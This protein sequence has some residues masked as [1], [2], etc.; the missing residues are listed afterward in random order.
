MVFK[1]NVAA[2]L[3]SVALPCR[4]VAKNTRLLSTI[5]VLG[6]VAESHGKDSHLLNCC[7]EEEHG[8]LLC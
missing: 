6:T 5:A 3:R 1:K 4:K 2:I 7:N 8:V